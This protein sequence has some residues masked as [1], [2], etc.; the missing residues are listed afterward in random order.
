MHVGL[1]QRE[2]VMANTSLAVKEWELHSS[3]GCPNAGSSLR[4]G[5]TLSCPSFI[6]FNGGLGF[7]SSTETCSCSEVPLSK[8]DDRDPSSGW[9]VDLFHVKVDTR[10]FR[11]LEIQRIG[12]ESASKKGYPSISGI[13]NLMRKSLLSHLEDS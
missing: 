4:V 6:L 3:S 2:E 11:L 12:E 13:Q 7:S 10:V 5:L 8:P 1:V 9:K